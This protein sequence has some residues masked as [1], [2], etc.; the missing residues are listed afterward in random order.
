MPDKII[1]SENEKGHE[2]NNSG[3][4]QINDQNNY[5]WDKK[6]VKNAF[7][8]VEVKNYKTFNNLFHETVKQFGGYIAQEEQNESDDK[9]ENIVLVKVPVE[10]FE[11]SLQALA[12]ENEKI[13]VKKVSSQDV[14]GDIVD[15]KSRIE[16]KRVVRLRY[17]DM[18]K[19]AKNMEE[20]IQ[21]QKEINQIQEETESAEGRLNYLSHSAAMSTIQLTFYEVLIPGPTENNPAGYGKRLLMAMKDG[22][23]WVGEFLLL[24]LT[25]WPLWVIAA[26]LLWSLKK[27]RSPKPA[28]RL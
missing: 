14:T 2:E 16:S 9:I 4:R 12:P 15:I 27:W 18:L 21:I 5:N 7:V 26:I 6:V 17:L 22:L 3:N 13:I 1:S 28:T 20:I 10:A 8:T 11:Q 23:E 25:V 19:Q 24:L